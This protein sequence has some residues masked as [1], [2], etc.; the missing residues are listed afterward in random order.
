N[1]IIFPYFKEGEQGKIIS[2]PNRCVSII[3]SDDINAFAVE[4]DK[5]V[6]KKYKGSILKNLQGEKLDIAEK[7]LEK[8]LNTYWVAMLYDDNSS[9]VEQYK[10]LETS[11]GA[12]KNIRFLE[13][14]S[15]FLNNFKK[16][17]ICGERSAVFE[18]EKLCAVC[19]QKRT[20]EKAETASFP[21]TA[22]ISLYH[23]EHILKTDASD[24]YNDYRELFSGKLPEQCWYAAGI[25]K[26]KL[27]E[28]GFK[29]IDIA[30]VRKKLK[31]IDK[32]MKESHPEVIKYRYYSIVAFDGDS[33]G[34]WIS[35]TYFKESIDT[36][37]AQ[38]ALS[39][40]L[41]SFADWVKNEIRTDDFVDKSKVGSVVYAGGED[42]LGVVPL[43]N[44]FLTMD[45]LRRK[46]MELVSD[47]IRKY[48]KGDKELT[49]SMGVCIAH[50]KSPLHHVLKLARSMVK[51]AKEYRDEKNMFAITLMKRSGEML[52]TKL[53]WHCNDLS[54]PILLNAVS[55]KF[56]QNSAA[57]SFI[58]KIGSEFMFNN[59]DDLNI[60]IS[61]LKS[62]IKRLLN[63]SRQENALK[64][65]EIE[66][67]FE[68]IVKLV[69]IEE[70]FNI[71]INT[72]LI[73]EF[74]R[75]EQDED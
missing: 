60:P 19:Y 29:D 69:S 27:E 45:L 33:M 53:P 25:E 71:L 39:K 65:E 14:S 68:D 8:H 48:I 38:I 5:A 31:S 12:I 63:R 9:Y 2:F 64:E 10:K 24:L 67:L 54:L 28:Q 6:K 56:A 16:C 32:Y 66:D 4:L 75:R 20:Y 17:N 18:K 49:L 30:T 36:E 35:G 70:N 62:E 42:F 41:G 46:F 57:Y 50:Y 58:N 52:K 34:K 72:L 37:E 22:S 11:M 21:S 44:L 55:D 15:N 3:D 74:I 40:A 43:N 59:K 47:A 26:S 51:E 73:C 1:K 7:Q 13:R 61:M 23:W